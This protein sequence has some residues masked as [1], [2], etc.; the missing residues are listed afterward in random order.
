MNLNNI[1]EI[2]LNLMSDKQDNL[3]YT[4]KEPL[5]GEEREDS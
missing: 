2:N 5:L 4:L 3:D 1:L